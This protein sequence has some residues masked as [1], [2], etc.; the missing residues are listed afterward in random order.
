[1]FCKNKV[2][3]PLKK[4][5]TVT[6]R[7]KKFNLSRHE[8][9][10]RIN[11]LNWNSMDGKISNLISLELT[12]SLALSELTLGG[13]PSVAEVTGKDGTQADYILGNNTLT[14]LQMGEYQVIL[15]NPA[16]PD[17][18]VIIDYT[19]GTADV[20]SFVWNPETVKIY[21]DDINTRI[22]GLKI[23]GQE[24]TSLNL[25]N[26]YQIDE[27]DCSN[28]AIPL[29]QLYTECFPSTPLS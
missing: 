24:V 4:F 29:S 5:I 26:L 27:P 7:H 22:I 23:A 6:Y 14:F 17:A 25:E 2:I 1:M 13:A 15:T 16:L 9:Y 18:Q 21:I 8:S 28:N 20:I 12:D 19:V 3:L 11:S 10:T